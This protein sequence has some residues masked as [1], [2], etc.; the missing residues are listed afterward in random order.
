MMTHAQN[1]TI[2]IGRACSCGYETSLSDAAID[3]ELDRAAREWEAWNRAVEQE[4]A[5]EKASV[6]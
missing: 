5:Q 6:L 2:Y 4:E 1:C 3:A